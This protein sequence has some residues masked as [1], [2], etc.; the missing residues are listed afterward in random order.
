MPTTFAKQLV[1]SLSP[2]NLWRHYFGVRRISRLDWH[3]KRLRVFKRDRY[4]CV[5]CGYHSKRDLHIHHANRNPK[6]NSIRNLEAVCPMCHLILHA[7]YAAEILGVLDFYATAKFSQNEIVLLTR[8]LRSKGLP[9]RKI[10][11]ALG[12]RDRRP[13]IP[14]PHYLARLTGFISARLPMDDRVSRALRAMYASERR[15]PKFS[16]IGAVLV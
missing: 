14:D 16:Q 15:M 7:G 8:R 11:D 1:A 3:H 2:P 6:A 12:L 9:D 5:Y 10:K 13:F 4:R